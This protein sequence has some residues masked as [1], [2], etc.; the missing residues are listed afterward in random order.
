M[1]SYSGRSRPYFFTSSFFLSSDTNS[2]AFRFEREERMSSILLVLARALTGFLKNHSSPFFEATQRVFFA[3][4]FTLFTSS[5]SNLKIFF[6]RKSKR[7]FS[8]RLFRWLGMRTTLVSSSLLAKKVLP[9]VFSM[10]IRIF[11]GS[12]LSLNQRLISF[13]GIPYFSISSGTSSTTLSILRFEKSSARRSTSYLSAFASRGSVMSHSP[14]SSFWK[15]MVSSS[16]L[17]V[18]FWTSPEERARSFSPSSFSL[19]S[20]YSKNKTK[21]RRTMKTAKRM[22]VVL[23]FIGTFSLPKLKFL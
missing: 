11:T 16:F 21:A 6:S 13:W 12:S 5:A 9:R 4:S 18:I 14:S 10:P 8:I 22:I 20:L 19:M 1:I 17:K 15:I 23:N 3:R 2:L 7:L